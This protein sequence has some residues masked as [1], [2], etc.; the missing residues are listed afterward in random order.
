MDLT[1]LPTLLD[2]HRPKIQENLNLTS[3][4]W[5]L[6]SGKLVSQL[7]QPRQ[8]YNDET[9]WTFL[10]AAVY[11]A[12]GREG[13]AALANQ[14]A[15][16]PQACLQGTPLWLEALPIPPRIGEGNSNIDLACGGIRHRAG[17]EGGIEF[18]PSVGD[19]AI[20]C[21][22]KWYSDISKDVS[23]DPHRNQ[24]AR[25]IE[26]AVTFQSNGV[27]PSRVFVTLVTPQG[28][29]DRP[30]RS[31]FYRYKFEEY[32]DNPNTLLAEWEA[33]SET[34]PNRNHPNWKYPEIES[35]ESFVNHKL[36]LIWLSFE[37]LFAAAPA[38]EIS[39][40]IQSFANSFNGTKRFPTNQPS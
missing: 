29:R 37:E 12:S 20:L 34:M 28:F 13:T 24:L 23:N 40:E 31:R 36:H 2:R 26:N 30:I 14:L 10:L 35:L 6:L 8:D 32:R 25:V 1:H 18:A 9:I 38:N 33:T 16:R 3:Q 21:E 17:K 22:M 5:E 27:F 7:K 11:A 19:W 39:K 15:G 4:R